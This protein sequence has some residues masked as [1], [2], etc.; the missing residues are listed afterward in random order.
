[1][2]LN[3]FTQDAMRTESVVDKIEINHKFVMNLLDLMIAAGSILD[4]VKKN[5][6][7]GKPYNVEEVNRLKSIIQ[8]SLMMMGDSDPNENISPSSTNPRIFHAIVGMST[9]STELLEALDMWDGKMDPVNMLE[10]IGDMAW[11]QAILIDELNGDWD[12]TL[13]TV[14]EKLRARYPEKFSSDHAINRDLNR[15][16]EILNGMEGGGEIDLVDALIIADVL[17][18]DSD[19]SSDPEPTESYTN[20]ESTTS[21]NDYSGSSSYSSG[22]SDSSYSDSG[23]SYSDSG[24]CGG[25]D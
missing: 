16:R 21:S 4:Q 6:F 20:C 14:I 12:R 5:A 15:E 13:N 11:Y 19:E 18:G 2:D 23:S 17:I 8:H 9:E 1:M 3:Q 7:Y 22:Y 24:S 10:E 25:G